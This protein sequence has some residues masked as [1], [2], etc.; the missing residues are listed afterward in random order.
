MAQH[1]ASRLLGLLK[2]LGSLAVL[3]AF[4][5]SLVLLFP[6]PLGRAFGRTEAESLEVW[7]QPLF[8]LGDVQVTPALLVKLASF[9]IL[10]TLLSRVSRRFLERR[11]L[12]RLYSDEG[13]R[14][15]ISR[16][17]GY[18]VFLLGLVI[19]LQTLGVDL[20]SVA[21]L[22]GALG[23]GVGFGLQNVAGNF[24]SGLILLFERP[25]RIGDRVEVGSLVGNVIKIA[26]R[27][28]WVR[29]NDNV[30]IVVPNSEFVNQRVTNWTA[31]DRQVRFSLPVGVAYGSDPALVR[32]LML[33]TARENRDVLPEPPP[34]VLFLGFG[35]SSLD[36]ELRVWTVTQVERP[37]VLKSGIYFRLFEVFREH[38][39]EIPFPQRD[40]HLR[41]W[42]AELGPGPQQTGGAQ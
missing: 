40:L 8:L 14:Y 42:P 17:T 38:G 35:E 20:S 25:I 28:T 23:I 34:E 22:G 12:V 29:T 21:V 13:Q 3:V 2:T 24:V 31:N 11:V 33:Q 16:V 18:L 9:L 7:K 19:G 26:A 30:I 10:L 27:S 1:G 36:F 4:L 32:E 5:L 41:S 15:A 6:K 37:R 39:V